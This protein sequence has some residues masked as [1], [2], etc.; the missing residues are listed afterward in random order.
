MENFK[1]KFNTLEEAQAFLKTVSERFEDTDLHME[2][3][4]A[5]AEVQAALADL[6]L[7]ETQFEAI[8]RKKYMGGVYREKSSQIE[9]AAAWDKYNHA[10]IEFQMAKRKL[11][12]ILNQ[13]VT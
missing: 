1:R 11:H 4:S 5:F 13:T 10:S 8:Q 6:L 2:F 12:D 3:T 7:S 9:I